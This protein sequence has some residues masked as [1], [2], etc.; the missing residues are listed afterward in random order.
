MMCQRFK[1]LDTSVRNLVVTTGHGQIIS[2]RNNVRHRTVLAGEYTGSRLL[3]KIKSKILL[4][5][6]ELASL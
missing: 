5:K 4:Q 1:G 6:V 2:F 3:S